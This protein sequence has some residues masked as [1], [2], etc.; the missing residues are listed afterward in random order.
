MVTLELNQ[1]SRPTRWGLSIGGIVITFVAWY[2]VADVFELVGDLALPSPIAVAEITVQAQ[3][4][5]L[6]SL[7]TTLERAA[8]GY[9]GAVVLALALAVVLTVNER[10][11]RALMPLVLAAN[12]VPRVSIA[13]LIVFYLGD[14]S[15]H[16]LI[17]GWVAFF[18]ILINAM[19]G[20][21]NLDEELEDLLDALGASRYQE[22]RLVRL[23]NALPF[24]FDGL[25]VGVSLAVVGAIVGE[26][27]SAT[28]G[29][30]FLALFAL[31]NYDVAL[32]FSVIGLMA[33]VALAAFLTLYLMQDRIVHWREAA[34]FPE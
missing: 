23:P 9:V 26:F 8:T 29:I 13:P 18:P 28:E 7:V 31:K 11:R 17:A 19:E 22:Y 30:G 16:A 24:I 1:D 14:F 20:F 4:I 27:V 34:L 33:L 12:T 10:I 5:L 32:V 25:K 21:G 6:M 3:D 15:P 2:L